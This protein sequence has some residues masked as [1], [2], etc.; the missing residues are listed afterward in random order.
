[1][2][3]YRSCKKQSS[4]GVIIV[5]M[6]NDILNA[7]DLTKVTASSNEGSV[8]SQ[9]W[10]A[11][12][13]TQGDT[14]RAWLPAVGDAP[15]WLQYHLTSAKHVYRVMLH[16]VN[17]MYGQDYNAPAKIQASNDGTN[18]TDLASFTINLS[19]TDPANI[20]VLCDNSQAWSY[21]RLWSE[22]CLLVYGGASCFV[23]EMEI[24]GAIAGIS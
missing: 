3:W 10:Y 18:W 22:T 20:E 23:G 6:V 4:G 1:M 19:G 8:G 16:C 21:V 15:C 17:N 5:D 7:Q 24:W 14:S 11:S 9:E 13:G 12:D 2:A